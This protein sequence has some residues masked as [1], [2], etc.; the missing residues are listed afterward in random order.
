MSLPPDS[1]CPEKPRYKASL[2]TSAIPHSIF[3]VMEFVE[4]DL[5]TLLEEMQE[6]F[7]QSEI[8]TI[9]HQI[10]SATQ[11]LHSNWIIHRDLKTSNLLMNNRGEVKLADF[12]LARYT[13][14]PP[15]ELT[16]RVVTL[17]YRSPELL[18][19]TQTYGTEI[20][21]WSVGCIFAELMTKDPL[22][23]GQNE[24]GQL[25]KIF[26]LLGPPSRE[27]WPGFQS[28]PNA[29][30][31]RP[32]VAKQ[33]FSIQSSFASKFPYVTQAGLRLMISML[34]MNPDH[35]PTAAEILQSQYFREDPKPK[36]KALFPT[37]PSKAGQERRRRRATPQAPARGEAPKMGEDDL[38]GLFAGRA[39][40]EQGA[41]FTLRL[42]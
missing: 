1:Y 32:L 33:N 38:A 18:L 5:K 30:A 28:L 42:G 15:P 8:K 17:W 19:G 25:S 37:F 27:I 34:A 16:Q 7:L 9:M 2:T 11:H 21:I 24:V 13:G 10:V 41:G 36:A 23:Q 40:E 12:G 39:E 20:D 29:K 35:R 3:L 4:H 6:P 14:D 31:I 26:A 22:F